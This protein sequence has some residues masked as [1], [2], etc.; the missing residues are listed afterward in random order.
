MKE[1][2][3][4]ITARQILDSRGNPTIETTI[5]SSSGITARASVPSGASVGK[6]EAVELRDRN[7]DY[8]NGKSVIK[9]VTNINDCIL[10][11]L[12]GKD[13]LNQYEIDKIMCDAD[14]TK[15][16]SR[17]GANAIL[18]VSLAAARLA[19]KTL[20]IPIFKY[21][22]G[23]NANIL[24]VPF[25]NILN[26]GVHADNNLD[27]QEFMIVPLNFENFSEALHA[28]YKI[29]NSLKDILKK[30]RLSVS[31]GDEGGFAPKISSNEEAINY[32]TDAIIEAGYDDKTVKIALDIASSELYS[33]GKYNIENNQYTSEEFC[34]YLKNLVEKYPI[35]SIEDGMAQDDILGWKFLSKHL[36]DKIMLVGDDL[37]VTNSSRIKMCIEEEI[38]NSVLIKLNQIGTLSE[39]LEAIKTAKNSGYKTIIS[40]R[41]GETCDSFIADL[42]VGVNAGYIKTGS[43]S[44]SERIEK[45]NRLLEI[46]NILQNNSKYSLYF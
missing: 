27:F 38:A 25:I 45:Y 7:Q 23:I 28:G 22:G 15:N 2:I 43:L 9:A 36:S 16:K 44:R 18:S 32:L 33:G 41:S 8:Y 5:T 21:I 29:F 19:A 4:K 31:V 26:G 6:F 17:L 24:P 1:I 30:N 12:T 35:Y 14:E 46:E 13:I 20:N 34:Y 40:H 42:A 37:M 10:E 39:T 3:S 11:K